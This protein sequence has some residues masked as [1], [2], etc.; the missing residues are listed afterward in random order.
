MAQSGS[1]GVFY[2]A[3]DS[4]GFGGPAVYKTILIPVD[5]ETVEAQSKAIATGI[6]FA[7]R[8]GAS[9]HMIYVAPTW[10][11]HLSET[12]SDYRDRFE[13]FAAKQAKSAGIEVATIFRPSGSVSGQIQTAAG[14][15]GADLIVMSSHDPDI[16]D[17]LIGSNAAHVV[18]HAS[19]SVFVVR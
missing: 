11:E 1:A 6:E 9:V 15:I 2:G 10:P 19:C 3:I 13:T 18:L 7:K 16:T 17:F 12:P 8:Y 5:M 14:D 4:L